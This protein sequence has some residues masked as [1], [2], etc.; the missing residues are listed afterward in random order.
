MKTLTARG[1]GN[2]RDEC[3][4]HRAKVPPQ[5]PPSTPASLP[6]QTLPPRRTAYKEKSA[7]FTGWL[8]TVFVK[9]ITAPRDGS[10]AER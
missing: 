1:C 9:R 7:A 2:S 3:E 10:P 6:N 4:Q 5:P 8:M